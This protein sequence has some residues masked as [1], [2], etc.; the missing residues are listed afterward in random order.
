M[1]RR[2]RTKSEI[3]TTGGIHDYSV[4]ATDMDALSHRLLNVS[5]KNMKAV[6]RGLLTQRELADITRRIAI[7]RMVLDDKTYE[8]IQ[9]SLGAGKM[10][11]SLV[12]RAL[13]N[14]DQFFEFVTTHYTAPN[15]TNSDRGIS[16]VEKYIA[17]RLKKGK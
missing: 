12:R 14:N 10:T 11:I 15:R 2:K 16:D 1:A 17:R 8:D 9:K 4:S 7:A 3:L 13:D 5:P 6:L